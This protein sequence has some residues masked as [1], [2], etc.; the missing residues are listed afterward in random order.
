[1]R[2]CAAGL[3][4]LDEAGLI[5]E[6]DGLDAVAEVEFVEDMAD[7]APDPRFCEVGRDAA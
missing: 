1:M 5:G 4:G 6:D 2:Y 7:V 3:T